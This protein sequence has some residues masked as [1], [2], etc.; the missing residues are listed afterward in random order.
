[1]NIAFEGTIDRRV[2]QVIVNGVETPVVNG[3]YTVSLAMPDRNLLVTISAV[4]PEGEDLVQRLQVDR[5]TAKA[6]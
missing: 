4:S 5:I 6:G 1:M 2:T 3:V